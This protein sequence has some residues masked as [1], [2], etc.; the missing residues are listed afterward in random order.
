MT[1]ET[2]AEIYDRPV[3]H[4]TVKGIFRYVGI[5]MIRWRS[6]GGIRICG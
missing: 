5:D 1:A 3:K 2:A 4:M 6:V